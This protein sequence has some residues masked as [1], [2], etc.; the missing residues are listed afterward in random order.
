MTTFL[1]DTNTCVEILRKRNAGVIATFESQSSSNVQ[2]CSVVIAELVFG[3]YRSQKTALNLSLIQT[4]ASPLV[5]LPFDDDAARIYGQVRNDLE[6]RGQPIGPNDTMIAS[7]ALLHG[8]TLVTHNRSE[9]LRVT[10]LKMID[11]HTP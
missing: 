6:S 8:V 5:S 9:F 3:A 10:G 4:F 1:L 11:W 2:L 7:I